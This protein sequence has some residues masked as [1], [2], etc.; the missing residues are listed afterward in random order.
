MTDHEIAMKYA[1]VVHFD[2]NETIPL[3]AVGYTV[4]RETIASPSFPKR[5]ILVGGRTAFAIEYAFYWDYDIQ[6]MYD[7]EHIWVNVDG[8]GRVIG[9]EGSFHGG[10]LP[11]M[12]AGSKP[13]MDG[14]HVH[15]YCQPGKHAFAGFGDMFRVVPYW[16][17]SCREMAGGDVLVG[18]PFSGAYTPTEEDNRLCDW[19]LKTHLTFEATL[20]FTGTAPENVAWMPWEELKALIPGWIR[21]ECS[22]LRK[23][24]GQG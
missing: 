4:V 18:G 1:P 15:A 2:Q 24:T 8:D 9:A 5:N 6:H 23:L 11:L 22:R 10:F 7:L 20:K 17:E 21:E 3:R 12:M 16:K 13:P 14:T 19:Y